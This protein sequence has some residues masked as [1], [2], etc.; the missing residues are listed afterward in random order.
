MNSKIEYLQNVESIKTHLLSLTRNDN[1]IFEPIYFNKYLI[2]VSAGSSACSQP[3]LDFNNLKHFTHVE[4]Q[5][6]DEIPEHQGSISPIIPLKDAR[7]GQFE[8]TKY[9]SFED[10]KQQI[11]GSYRGSYIPIDE[12]CKIIKDIYKVSRFNIF[13]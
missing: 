11:V 10:W 13:T 1:G 4:I 2:V 3:A 6:F 5:I 8:W 9:F 7:F 12:A